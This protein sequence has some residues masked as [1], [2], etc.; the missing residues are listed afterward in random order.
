MTPP[1]Q[2]SGVG[3]WRGGATEGSLAPCGTDCVCTGRQAGPWLG[4]GASGGKARRHLALD[5]TS[6]PG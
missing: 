6:L 2:P 1:G 3:L 4:R 5:L